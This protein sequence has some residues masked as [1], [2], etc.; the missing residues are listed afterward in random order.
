MNTEELQKV[1]TA[2]KE[3]IS[4]FDTIL[5]HDWSTGER[6]LTES[7]ADYVQSI[8]TLFEAM[9]WSVS[10]SLTKETRFGGTK[11]IKGKCGFPVKIC[12]ISKEDNPDQEWFFGI[13]LGEVALS[14]AHI[15]SGKVL[16]S[17][18]SFYNPAIY[19]PDLGKIVYGVESWWEEIR[20]S[21]DLV[22]IA[23]V[24]DSAL[25]KYLLNVSL[26]EL[27]ESGLQEAEAKAD[28]AGDA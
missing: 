13:F 5:M 20:A 24:D 22:G 25:S 8:I 28:E 15:I 12:P 1:M 17:K 2:I 11:P 3:D 9:D 4:I 23:S 6:K 10:L 21:A 14:I 19:V 26:K 27:I 18:H 7:Q 16:T